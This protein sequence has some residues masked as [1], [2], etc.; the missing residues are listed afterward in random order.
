MQTARRSI[1]EPV[2]DPV[3][4]PSI[5]HNF[6]VSGIGCTCTSLATEAEVMPRPVKD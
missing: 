5:A 1:M 6:S 2:I 4:E 3:R